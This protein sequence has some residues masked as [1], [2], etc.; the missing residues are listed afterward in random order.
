MYYI[1]FVFCIFI[2]IYIYIIVCNVQS[3]LYHVYLYIY[4][5]LTTTMPRVHGTPFRSGCFIKARLPTKN[6]QQSFSQIWPFQN[7][8]ESEGSHR[9]ALLASWHIQTRHFQIISLSENT[10]TNNKALDALRRHRST[11]SAWLV[12]IHWQ[13]RYM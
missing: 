9:F 5:T 2:Y 10:I 3:N 6:C 4:K 13:P 12:N 7:L 1:I 8:C 11:E